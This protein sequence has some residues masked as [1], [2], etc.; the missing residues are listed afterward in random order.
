MTV[1]GDYRAKSL[2]KIV[3][4]ARRGDTGVEVDRASEI[5]EG[6]TVL[7]A[8]RE[9][10]DRSLKTYLYGGDPGDIRQGKQIDTKMLVR[11]KAVNGAYVK[12]DR[13][14]RFET[15]IGWI[16]EIRAFRPTVTKSGIEGLGFEFPATKYRGHFKGNGANAIEL[17]SIHNCWVRDV[18]IRNGDFSINLVACGNTLDGVVFTADSAAGCGSNER[19]VEVTGPHGVQCKNAEDNLVT[20]FDF[21][22]SYVHDLSVE[23]ASGNVFARGGGVNLC[24]DHHKDTPYEN[25]FTDI[26]CGRGTRVWRC[27][28]SAGLGRQS[29]SWE[30]FWNIRAAGPFEPPPAGWGAPGMNFVGLAAKTANPLEP[31]GWFERLPPE[32]LRRPIFTPLSGCGGW[33]GCGNRP[34]VRGGLR[35]DIKDYFLRILAA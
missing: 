3:A 10:P 25:L 30:T 15:R 31:K 13:P 5:A 4:V 17:R 24:S 12:F 9:T 33:A 34:G 29:A 27:G 7:V 14:L 28:G 23:H 18:A 20:R 21:R 16:P 11:V 8:L 6:Q 19:G 32:Q 2:A 26:D 22:T 35:G 1:E